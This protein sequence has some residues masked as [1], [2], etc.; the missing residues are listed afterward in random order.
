MK[1]FA[2]ARRYVL[3]STG[4]LTL[5]TIALVGALILL[6]LALIGGAFTAEL[7]PVVMWLAIICV[8]LAIERRH[9]GRALRDRPGPEWEKT[10]EQFLDDASGKL[11]EVWY[12]SKTGERRYI[13]HT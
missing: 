10:N 6:V 2:M 4:Y 11:V 1:S 3:N 7:W 5:R 13:E 9:Y 8:A 12:N